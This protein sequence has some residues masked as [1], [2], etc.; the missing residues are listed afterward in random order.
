L[1]LKKI[2]DLIVSE[3]IS[4]DPRKKEIV[5]EA[6]N[7]QKKYFESLSQKEKEYFD[8][9][10]LANPYADSRLLNG[11]PDK[12]I[13]TALVGIDMDAS[14]LLLIDRL[15]KD[16]KHEKIDLAISHHP[17]GIAY[18][19]FYEVMDMQAD[20]FHQLGIP[21]NITEGL[22][23]ERKKEVGRRV[24][25]ANHQRSTDMAKLLGIPFLCAHTPADNHAVSYL[26]KMFLDKKPH[27]L[28]DIM[29]I[30]GSIEEYR[31]SKKEHVSPSILFGKSDSR[32]GKIFVDMT[33]GTEGP[34]EIIDNLLQAGVGTLVG[35]HLSEEHYKKLQGKNI[36]VIV[37]GHIAS[38]NLGMNLLLDK[39]QKT[40]KIKLLACSGFR[41]VKR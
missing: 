25:A 31:I 40:S 32:V 39:I 1:K 35:M 11:D 27:T 10:T 26:E 23:E 9:E 41:R 12:D 36:N 6:L 29:D 21:I 28:R 4:A 8:K 37:A 14:E 15:N 18:A 24:H 3:G 2:Y 5:E 33:G 16:N 17:Q 20:I 7:K 34:K 22:V 13:R 38:D 19:S 30:L